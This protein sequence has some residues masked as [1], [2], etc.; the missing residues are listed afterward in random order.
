MNKHEDAT[1]EPQA[2]QLPPDTIIQDDAIFEAIEGHR[3]HRVF[4]SGHEH[5]TAPG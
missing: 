2:F 4:P 5:T 3:M 1:P